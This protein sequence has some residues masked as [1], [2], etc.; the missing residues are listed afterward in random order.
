VSSP[1]HLALSARIADLATRFVNFDIPLDR[2]ATPHELDMIASFKL[3][4]HAEF[5]TFIESRIRDTIRTGVS[6]WKTDKRTTRALFGLLLR[7]YP[8]FENERN[9][10]F[11]PKAFLE[12]SQLL[13]NL[14]RNAEQ[15]ISD[16]NG[17]KKD[18]FSRLCY[19]AG[20]AL[21]ES[22]PLLL[23]ALES[24]GKNRG[25]IAHNAVGKVRTLKDPRVE[26]SDAAQIVKFLEQFDQQLLQA[27][28]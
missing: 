17:I 13:D 8:Y 6:I 14:V 28:S 7:W 25:E 23:A 27:V 5:E 24:Y 21:D 11:L 16:N 18:A 19:S 1:E 4:A 26:A 2:D 3:L 20:L 22:S 10:Y 9:P 15:E 12:I